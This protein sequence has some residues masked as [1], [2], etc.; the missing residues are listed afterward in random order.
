MEPLENEIT[1]LKQKIEEL[2]KLNLFHITNGEEIQ[3]RLKGEIAVLENRKNEL[4]QILVKVESVKM[5]QELEERKL[6]EMQLFHKQREQEFL[7]R[8]VKIR[9]KELVL[10]T[11]EKTRILLDVFYEEYKDFQ[12]LNARFEVLS[13]EV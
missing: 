11:A 9:E 7:Q 8:E 10:E 5:Q 1:A 6:A 4:H 12:D 3:S 13:K 2:K